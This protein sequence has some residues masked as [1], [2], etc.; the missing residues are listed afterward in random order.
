MATYIDLH[1]LQNV[2]PSCLNRDDTGAPK[3]AEYGGVTRHRV[4]SQAWK[5][6]MR[7]YFTEHFD[8]QYLGTR[9]VH[10]TDTIIEAMLKQDSSLSFEEA[11]E[12]AQYVV[13]KSGIKTT[14]DDP[15]STSAL[16][17]ISQIELD[18]LAK[19]AVQHMQGSELDKKTVQK[20]LKGAQAIDI[21]LFGRMLADAPDLNVDAACQVQH[22]ISVTPAKIEY[23]Y[24]TAVDD[25]KSEDNAGAAMIGTNEFISSTLYRYINI[26]V[27]AL[28]ASIGDK[29]LAIQAV[30]TAIRAF[31]L[32][33]PS[34][35]QNT[36]AANTRPDF[37]M[38]Q[39]RNDQPTNLVSAF[40]T[41]VRADN[42]MNKAAEE[43]LKLQV[44]LDELYGTEALYTG[45]VA[46]KRVSEK[47][48]TLDKRCTFNDL[49]DQISNTLEQ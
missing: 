22:A 4:S 2:P 6:A 19:L 35:R 49:I 12:A 7:A 41:P 11:D 37:V 24:F 27:D 10:I 16:L 20:A 26:N 5:H 18:A 32:S 29:N 44:S 30:Q 17:F 36:F 34:G 43:L 39:V 38:A 23:D 45:V 8:P 48:L 15:R 9:T 14:K 1:V 28:T 25:I 21:S 47:T 33:M 42:I 31:V 46:S 40:E 3:T 13:S